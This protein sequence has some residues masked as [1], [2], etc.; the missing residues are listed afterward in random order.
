M[1]LL[2]TFFFCITWTTSNAQQVQLNISAHAVSLPTFTVQ[3]ASNS[4]VEA[5]GVRL[6]LSDYDLAPFEFGLHAYTGY[7]EVARASLGVNLA[8]L[9][10]QPTSDHSIKV[11][12]SL[13]KIDL[14]DIEANPDEFGSHIG[15][16]RFTTWANEF[17]P[18]VE[19]KWNFLRFASLFANTGYRVINGEK[20][21]VTAV[22]QTGDSVWDRRVTDR[23]HTFFY[24]ASGFE[25]GLGLSIRIL[26][27]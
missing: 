21:V 12:L 4:N 24:S 1:R 15:D 9:L 10:I 22:K 26:S 20:S 14:E 18:Y 5:Y 6:M 25:F 17:K 13:S 3:E 7:G 11:G 2:I 19:W 23:E 16:L 8:Y 27:K